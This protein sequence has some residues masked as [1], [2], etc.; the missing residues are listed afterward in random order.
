M[1]HGE[2][3]SLPAKNVAQ[4]CVLVVMANGFDETETIAIISILRQAG[5]CIKSVGLASGLVGSVHGL[6]LMPDLTLSDLD[7]LVKTKFISMVILPENEK[8]LAKLQ[9]DP[10][11]LKFLGQVIAQRGQIAVGPRGMQLLQT[12]AMQSHGLNG[13]S[14]DSTSYLLIRKLDQSTEDF[15]HDLVRRLTQSLPSGTL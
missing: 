4:S 8:C 13:V 9:T 2:V 15:A 1:K 6:W 3:E 11:L 5:L 14:P 7:H 12:A 10:R